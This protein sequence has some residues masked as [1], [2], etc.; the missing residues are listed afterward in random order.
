MK[1]LSIALAL[2]L[3]VSVSARAADVDTVLTGLRGYWETLN[4]F[5]A[6]FVQKKH[7]SLFSDDVT[8]RGTFYYR[9]PGTMV[10]RFDHP[11]DTIIEIKPGLITYYHPGLKKATRYHAADIPQWMSFGMGPIN[12]IEALKDVAA[13]TAEDAAGMTVLTF[14]PNDATEAIVSIAI[15]MKRD[16][17]PLKIRI[18]ENNGDFTVIDFSEQRI[19]PPLS[20]SAFEVKLPGDVTIEDVGK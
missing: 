13:V 14:T 18:S 11:D 19:N 9:K 5:T 4:T 6:H 3:L 1:R 15:T 2:L 7:L 12:D 8:S 10:W 16:Y 17:T 20:D